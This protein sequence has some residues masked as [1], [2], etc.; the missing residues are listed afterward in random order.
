LFKSPGLKGTLKSLFFTTVRSLPSIKRKIAQEVSK[1]ALSLE[2]D[3]AK[4]YLSASPC[5]EQ[6]PLQGLPSSKVLSL[7]E[8]YMA[9]GPFSWQS[10]QC[11]GAVYGGT[12]ALSEL[13]T[14]VYSR[15]MWSN[16][17]HMNVFPGVCRME[18]EVVS[19]TND[20]FHG[21][22]P[23]GLITSGG[24]ESLFM[25]LK[26]YRD[27]ARQKR[28]ITRPSIVMP[29]TAH[30]AFDK[31]AHLLHVRLIKVRV[32]PE[33]YQVNPKDIAKAVTSS[34]VLIVVSAP[35]YPHGVIDPIPEVAAIGASKGIGV[36]VDSCLGGLLL[37]FME[38]AGFPLPHGFDFRVPGVTSI[39]ADTHKVSNQI[40]N[41]INN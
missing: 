16:A 19:M 17:L 31:A 40:K 2:Q 5:L 18:A 32:H 23:A 3:V 26:V 15:T 22:V 14:E 27:W 13:L 34:T 8:E 20:F 10:G 24:T 21:D 35:T 25:T 28:G 38:E 4:M 12:P 30:P 1:A 37:P 11:S 36:H 9:L 39:S 33:T 29:E 6:L 7:T 41:I